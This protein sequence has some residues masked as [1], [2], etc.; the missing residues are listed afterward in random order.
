MDQN[1]RSTV[2][3]RHFGSEV[4]SREPDVAPVRGWLS[5]HET[6][7]VLQRP[8]RAVR[9]MLRRGEVADA[10]PG[11]LRGVSVSEVEELVRGRPLAC[12]VLTAI[13]ERR[14]V[15]SSI[16]MDA[17]PPSLMESLDAVR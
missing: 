9:N 10:R 2:Q 7:V 3:A 14:L 13:L 16:G 4:G 15:I 5:L 8:V 1:E 12:A 6:A 17:I 11:R